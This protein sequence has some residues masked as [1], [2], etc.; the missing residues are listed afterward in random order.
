LPGKKKL[1]LTMG[2][3]RNG[4]GNAGDDGGKPMDPPVDARVARRR[5]DPI[6]RRLRKFYEEVV[7]ESVPDEFLSILEDVDVRQSQ[8]AS[9][10]D[11]D[12]GDEKTEPARGGRASQAER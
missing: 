3:D 7:E 9:D 10:D 1:Y 8:T 6:G 4:G 11:G 2:K 5:Q 12:D